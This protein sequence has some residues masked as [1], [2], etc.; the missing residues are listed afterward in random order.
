M[1]LISTLAGLTGL[2]RSAGGVAEAFVGNRA[3][4]ESADPISFAERMVGLELVPDP[5]WWL[6]GAIVSFY[7]GARELHYFREKRP[8]L[9][10]DALRNVAKRR[11]AI[12]EMR[13]D[14]PEPVV[15]AAQFG[16]AKIAPNANPALEE[17]LSL[18]T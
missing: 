10:V 5:L 7:F 15:A 6:L 11:A 1:G 8:H 3:E 16:T 4:L 17:W 13:P 12:G 14:T 2:V 9:D 18:Q